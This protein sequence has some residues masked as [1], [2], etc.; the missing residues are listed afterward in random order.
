MSNAEFL[1]DDG[2]VMIFSIKSQ[3]KGIPYKYVTLLDSEYIG[4]LQGTLKDVRESF[5]KFKSKVDEE[6]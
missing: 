2:S 1:E 6:K 5:D 3:Y 4:S